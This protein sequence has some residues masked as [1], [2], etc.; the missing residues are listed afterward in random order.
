MKKFT[1]KMTSFIITLAM[2]LTLSI[3]AFAESSNAEI[4]NT[5]FVED[6]TGGTIPNRYVGTQTTHSWDYVYGSPT[7]KTKGSWKHFYTGDPTQRDGEYD[8]ASH[9]VSYGHTYSGS[10]GGNIKKLIQVEFGISFSKNEEFGISKNSAP[11]KKGEYIKAYWKKS[12]NSYDVKQTDHQH[13]FGF[14][15]Q[16]SGGPY[17]KVDRY[18]DVVSHVTVDKA[19][20]PKIRIE[21]WK[22]NKKVRSISNGDTLERV[23]YYEL[24]NGK[25]QLVDEDR[26]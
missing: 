10:F 6:E 9:S 11:L 17:V 7:E 5:V 1:I 26:V 4:D 2:L 18:K 15:Q 24:I 21:Y 16:G 8:T 19:L 13:T 14:E 3:P 22:D 12:F 23:E 20:Q 25:Y